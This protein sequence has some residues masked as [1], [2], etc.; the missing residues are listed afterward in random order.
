[1]LRDKIKAVVHCDLAS[2]KIVE[3][4]Y[5]GPYDEVNCDGV[6]DDSKPKEQFM[7][8]VKKLSS[9][10]KKGGY[11]MITTDDADSYSF[12]G[13]EFINLLEISQ[14]DIQEAFFAAGFINVSYRCY[15]PYDDTILTLT[16]GQKA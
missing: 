1:M 9:L 7:E 6:L 5:E 11:L 8:G 12:S 4:G 2:S 10:V 3:E 14:E 15:M 16:I 13:I